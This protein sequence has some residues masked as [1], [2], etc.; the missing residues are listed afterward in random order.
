MA[1]GGGGGEG[2]GVGEKKVG[3]ILGK[4]CLGGC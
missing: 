2:G 3:V 4:N 1:A